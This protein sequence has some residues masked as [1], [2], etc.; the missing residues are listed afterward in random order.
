MQS[1]R[2]VIAVLV[3]VVLGAGVVFFLADTEGEKTQKDAVILG[4]S[5]LEDSRYEDALHWFEKA[6][7]QGDMKGQFQLAMMYAKGRGVDRD[8]AQA[9]HWLRLSAKQGDAQAQYQLALHMEHGRGI[10]AKPSEA[11]TWYLKAAAQGVGQAMFHLAALYAEGRGIEQS[12]EQA[13]HW[14]LL[15][16]EKGAADAAN[17]RKKIVKNILQKAG[18]G[19]GDAQYMLAMM[20]RESKGVSFSATESMRWMKKAAEHKN[21]NAAFELGRGFHFGLGADIDEVKAFYW[22]QIAAKNANKEAGLALG[23]LYLQ[24]LGTEKMC[25]KV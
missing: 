10:D 16:E 18:S 19:D 24:G 7:R 8:D 1:I 23:V 11:A 6:S 14:I 22:Y 5:A 15:A 12:D 21:S 9:V 17:F 20:Y 25:L 13:L 3:F 4:E 2:L